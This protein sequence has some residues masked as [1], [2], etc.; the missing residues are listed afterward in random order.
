[1]LV[2]DV[3]ENA[4]WQVEGIRAPPPNAIGYSICE[5]FCMGMKAGR[6]KIILRIFCSEAT[7]LCKHIDGIVLREVSQR[8]IFMDDSDTVLLQG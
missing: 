3:E 5:A 7:R 4:E 8:F 2:C 6:Q 1:M